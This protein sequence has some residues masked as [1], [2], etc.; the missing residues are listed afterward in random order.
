MNN[1]ATNKLMSVLIVLFL[2]ANI[3]TIGLY[4]FNR[5]KRLPPPDG[6]HGNNLF[7]FLTH[8]LNL[9]STQQAAYKKLITEDREHDKGNRKQNRLSKEAFFSLLSKDTVTP[10]ELKAAAAT[11]AETDAQMLMKTFEHF[12]KVRA[13]CNEEQK[14]KFDTVIKRAIGMMGQ[15]QGRPQGPPPNGERNGMHPDGP[16]PQDEQIPP[17]P[18]GQNGPPQ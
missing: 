11:A 12:K 5:E 17:P 1:V 13:L 7:M 8:E 14:K 6:K 16:P 10:E 4:W 3:S 15:Q 9:D 18:P 2:L